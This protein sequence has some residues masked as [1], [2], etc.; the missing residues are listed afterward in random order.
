VTHNESF[1]E[2]RRSFAQAESQFSDMGRQRVEEF[3]NMQKN[4]LDRFQETHDHWCDRA[5][6]ETS[7]ASEFA[8]KLTASRS[9]PEAVAAYQEWT[10]QHFDLMAKDGMHLFDDAQKFVDTCTRFM[11]N[12]GMVN[13]GR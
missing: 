13:T 2:A 10:G 1:A 7:L 12:G 8:S 11:S 9:I 5:Q 6:K 3:V 4:L